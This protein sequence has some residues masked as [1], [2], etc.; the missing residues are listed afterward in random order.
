MSEHWDIEVYR[1]R[2]KQ[3]QAAAD[4][5]P[6]GKEREACQIL[7]EGYTRLVKVIEKIHASEQLRTREQ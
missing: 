7:H 3:W 1:A 4:A 6:P 2:A 5:C